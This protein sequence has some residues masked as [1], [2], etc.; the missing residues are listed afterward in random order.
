[1]ATKDAKAARS[2]LGRSRQ[3]VLKITSA[4]VA[5]Q[6]QLKGKV[7]ELEKRLKALSKKNEPNRGGAKAKR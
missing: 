1:M 4:H 3:D 2:Q 6:R 7:R 5:E